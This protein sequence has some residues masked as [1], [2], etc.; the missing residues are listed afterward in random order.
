MLEDFSK[1]AVIQAMEENLRETGKRWAS[2][3]QAELHEG[4]EITWFVSGLPNDVTCLAS[5]T[6]T[7]LLSH[8]CKRFAN[9]L[10]E[11]GFE[12]SS[13]DE[14]T[15]DVGMSHEFADVL[16]S[17]AAAIEDTEALPRHVAVHFAI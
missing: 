11:V 3:L 1:L 8:H 4:P 2:L 12:A 6:V 9:D 7:S 10:D 13:A 5:L 17:D 15:V 16:R 14:R